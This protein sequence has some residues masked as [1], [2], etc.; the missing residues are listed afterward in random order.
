[1]QEEEPGNEAKL[2]MCVCVC[3]CVHVCRGWAQMCIAVCVCQ[4]F[5]HSQLIP[6]PHYNGLAIAITRVKPNVVLVN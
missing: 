3:V 5:M 6:S 2:A 1:M 4:S